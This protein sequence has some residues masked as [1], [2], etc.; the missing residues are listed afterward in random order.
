[1]ISDPRLFVKAKK[2][3][4]DKAAAYSLHQGPEGAWI[5]DWDIVKAVVRRMMRHLPT[6][7]YPGQDESDRLRMVRPFTD[8]ATMMDEIGT[9]IAQI[10]GQ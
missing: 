3:K 2:T 6:V 10:E 8:V 1:M 9:K 4:A 5:K 7:I